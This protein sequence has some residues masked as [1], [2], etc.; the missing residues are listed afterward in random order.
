M[1]GLETSPRP[2]GRSA[3]HAVPTGAQPERNTLSTTA[4]STTTQDVVII[5]EKK[6]RKGALLWVAGGAALLLGGSTFALWS[7]GAMFPGGDITAG[8][9]HLER[10]AGTE[11]WDVSSD[12]R[13]ATMPV[14]G[15]DAS[16]LGHHIVDINTWRIVPGDKVAASM[17]TTVTLEGDN[18]VARLS[19]HNMDNPAQDNP[20]LH[21]SYEIYADGQRV[22]D[23]A[24][25]PRGGDM[26]LAYL[27][28]PGVGQDAGWEDADGEVVLPMMNP[29]ME[30]TVVVYGSFFEDRNGDFR[31]TDEGVDFTVSGDIGV[32]LT[33]TLEGLNLHLEQVRDTGTQFS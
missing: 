24:P 30:Y 22:A 29:K 4:Q 9:L 3:N 6:R 1:T 18:L 16:Q 7:A 21:Y 8:D 14:P 17:T 10:S 28:A 11:F 19:L 2:T 15:T 20:D 26:T 5:E 31:Y 33:D 13:D 32:N 27:S 25:L 23:E 12:R